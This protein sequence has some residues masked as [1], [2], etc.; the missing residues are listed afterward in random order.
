[1]RKASAWNLS[2]ASESSLPNSKC[3]K[4]YF[5]IVHCF[6]ASMTNWAQRVHRF[7][8]LYIKCWDT[9]SEDTGLWQE[10]YQKYTLYLRVFWIRLGPLWKPPSYFIAINKYLTTVKTRGPHTSLHII[11]LRPVVIGALA[12]RS[13]V[14]ISLKV[15]HRDIQPDRGRLHYKSRPLTRVT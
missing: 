7:I 1:M 10:V 13:S 6:L 2:R 5:S 11:A 4:V 14:P 3:N 12:L 8:I 9:P 15:N